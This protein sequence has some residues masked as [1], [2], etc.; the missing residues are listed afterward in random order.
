[1][2]DTFSHFDRPLTLPSS[3]HHD[4]PLR[5]LKMDEPPLRDS[6]ILQANEKAA[7][8]MAFVHR[9]ISET[10]TSHVR[11][12]ANKE[13]DRFR[14]RAEQ[15]GNDSNVP[16][17]FTVMRRQQSESFFTKGIAVASVASDRWQTR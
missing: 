13:A 8:G 9:T 4:T 2:T 6:Q 12:L 1:M 15:K 17:A 11:Q 16:I 5:E 7:A 14:T 10:A 3:N